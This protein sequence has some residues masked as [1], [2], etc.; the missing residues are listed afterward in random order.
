VRA[1]SLTTLLQ[2]TQ[3][4][5]RTTKQAEPTTFGSSVLDQ[6]VVAEYP[7]AQESFHDFVM[8]LLVS[9][10]FPGDGNHSFA[11]KL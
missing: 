1:Y 11:C 5:I 8:G 3:D 6:A 10:T 9:V 2:E 7:Q 4:F